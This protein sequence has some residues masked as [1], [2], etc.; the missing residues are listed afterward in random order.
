MH[1]CCVYL[2]H[3]LLASGLWRLFAAALQGS[4]GSPHPHLQGYKWYVY[5]TCSHEAPGPAGVGTSRCN[6][7]L[8]VG[9]LVAKP[10]QL[11]VR[12]LDSCCHTKGSMAGQ[13]NLLL[14][15]VVS[16]TARDC[17]GGSASSDAQLAA[18]HSLAPPLAVL[19]GSKLLVNATK[20]A[21]RKQRQRQRA[22]AAAGGGASGGGSSTL[23]SEMRGYA[24]LL[25]RAQRERELDL[26]VAAGSDEPVH[27]FLQ[28]CDIY[29]RLRIVSTT[30]RQVR[31]LA[32]TCCRGRELALMAMADATGG[33]VS[34]SMGGC[35]GN[36]FGCNHT[37]LLNLVLL[38]T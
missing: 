9:Q 37:G 8:I 28:Q 22:A 4:Q 35:Q 36:C 11:V 1:W 32:H 24:V 34:G 18:A 31:L 21:K 17:F 20:P 5:M 27:G 13:Q 19:Y 25:Q 2:P 12:V 6:A 3:L 16:F 33:V 38:P 26:E 29:P 10:K 23:P 30:S 15:Q 14:Q 7:G